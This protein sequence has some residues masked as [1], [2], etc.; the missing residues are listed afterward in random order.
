MFESRRRIMVWAVVPAIQVA[1]VGLFP[2]AYGVLGH[3]VGIIPTSAIM[4]AAWLLGMR[5]AALAA[6]FAV[7]ANTLLFV[8][9]GDEL[10]VA[11]PAA[12]FATGLFL[13]VSFVVLRMRV[14]KERIARLTMFD[15]LTNLPNRDVFHARLEK[16]LGAG[17]PARIALVDV[18]G[19]REVNES[20]GHE[21][22]DEVIREIARRLRSTFEHTLVARLG[23]DDFAIVADAALPDDLF[24]TRALGVFRSPF[25]AAGSL[26]SVEGRVGIARSP[27]HGETGTIL[28][29]AAESAARS[30]RRLAAGW[31]VASPKR[32]QD[33]SARLRMLGELRQAFERGE[34][35]L[36]YQPLLD[37][38]SGGI[39]GFEALI[40]WQRSGELV[41]P[42]IFIPLAEQ[43]GLIV[44]LT[45]WV[46][47]EA[48]RQS[49]EW[50]RVGHS[51][52]ISINVGAKTIGASSR[53]E[54]VIAQAAA[55]H[56]VPASL[57]TVEV[58]ETDVMTDP[59]QA[60]RTLAGLK[61][62]GVRVAVD[63]FGTG[64]SSL[65]YLNELP[66]D[67]V[68]I[69]RSFISRLIT[70]PQTSSIVRAAI[71]LSHALGLD[72]VAEGV[73]DEATLERLVLLG[74]DRA[75]GYFI[76]RPMPADAVIPWLQRHVA[77]PTVI[78]A[79]QVA[80]L[81]PTPRTHDADTATVLVVD[82]EHA[83]R[84]ATHRILSAQGFNVLHAATASEA[85][86]ICGEQRGA[87]DL[88]V[89][90]IFLTD[91]RGHELAGR[92]REMQPDVKVL[93]VSGDP[94]AGALVNGAPFL[95]KPFS[96]QQLIDRVGSVLAA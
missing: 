52:N 44:P 15:A 7:I 89:T 41:S 14:D 74:C 90:D 67:E 11:L 34:L 40:R 21:V 32:S 5:A 60:S 30:A 82:D 62:L 72:A 23:T 77:T 13:V 76:A 94:K 25:V 81:I 26:L 63:D 55:A 9:A 46:I 59:V 80:A 91:W 42:A 88:V 71:D 54:T 93:F 87:I 73:E 28:M 3:V 12:S 84:V 53:L 85:L 48:A 47:D 95:A 38:T 66:L 79:P 61:K 31:A 78:S 96:K 39:V 70:D 19:F 35:R 49:A 69:D 58:T 22:G 6:A 75:Q 20:F 36:H 83:L 64:Y 18:I 50:A 86:R 33:S 8:S 4:L 1:Y 65:S 56:G 10:D 24:A 57:F 45:D 37:V 17:A 68:K 43:T 51:L 29:S 92:L 2:V 16:M 27:E